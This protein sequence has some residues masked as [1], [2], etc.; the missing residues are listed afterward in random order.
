M[1]CYDV[2]AFGGCC[3]MSLIR[4]EVLEP[5]EPALLLPEVKD[6]KHWWGGMIWADNVSTH[7]Y[8]FSFTANSGS[9]NRWYNSELYRP[10]IT[11]SE[12][13]WKITV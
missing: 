3:G 11:S 8:F 6:A 5:I 9:A 2:F 4:Q 7:K 10:S 12:I 13:T 1:R